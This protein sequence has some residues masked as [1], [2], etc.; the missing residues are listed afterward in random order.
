MSSLAP[1]T[2]QLSL[3]AASSARPASSFSGRVPAVLLAMAAVVFLANL[4]TVPVRSPLWL[5]ENFSATIASQSSFRG[6]VDWCLNELS[7]P[8]YYSLLWGWEKLAGNGDV[9]LRVPGLVILLATPLL[10]A[11]QGHRD[12]QIAALWAVT[13]GLWPFG[14][15]FAAE[16]RPYTL[17]VF[18]G[19]AQAI[20]FLRLIEA[21]T[22]RRAAIWA[23]VSSLLVLTHYHGAVISGVQG[24][25]YL[26]IWR[27]RALRTWP[28][29]F[30]LV[31]MAAWM[32]VHLGIVL[33]YATS[34]QTWY[35]L[36][37]WEDVLTSVLFLFGSLIVTAVI[38]LLVP[39]AVHVRRAEARAGGTP[40][41]RWTP[42]RAVIASG[43]IAVAIV[44]AVGFFRPSMTLRYL[45]PYLGAVSLT[46]PVLLQ[47][48]RSVAPM[49]PAAFVLLTTGYAVPQVVHNLTTHENPVVFNFEQPTEWILAQGGARRVVFLWDNPTALLAKPGKLED[50]AG[51]FFRRAGQPVEVVVPQ[52]AMNADPYPS[53]RALASGRADT[54]VI[55]SLDRGVP[56]TSALL[57]PVGV[58]ADHD[59][60]T[61]R[62]FGRGPIEVY[63]CMPKR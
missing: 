15:P 25:L 6:L 63:A 58:L 28:A 2:S 27:G 20:C 31:P 26:A 19:C 12:R 37:T 5:D 42:E 8:L 33:S 35:T 44:I 39:V 29:I 40:L 14:F 45:T 56:N 34:G 18:L 13:V 17:M 4:A 46:V 62:N 54:A 48:V 9:A 50:V 36:Y 16:A 59:R 23:G 3:P 10:L 21:P 52:Y 38:L 7:G 47:A 51:F 53:V 41:L 24:V 22:T 60:W 43:V 11:W 55:W 30:V 1:V 57:H 61:C 49:A 32:T